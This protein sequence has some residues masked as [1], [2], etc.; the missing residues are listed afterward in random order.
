MFSAIEKLARAGTLL[1]TVCKA[2]DDALRVCVTQIPSNTKAEP[3][4][5]P[6]SLVGT[7]EELDAGFAE[8]IVIWQAPRKSLAEQARA[9]ATDEDDDAVAPASKPK[10]GGAKRGS[11]PQAEKRA[12]AASTPAAAG[13]DGA[14]GEAAPT[15]G[16]DA[17]AGAAAAAAGGDV[18]P[19][20][21]A[22]H[23]TG[24]ASAGDD[25]TPAPCAVP[26]D[27]AED[28]FT[29]DLF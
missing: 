9:A 29:L 14:G 22:D 10:G 13:E 21:G 11:K 1:V 3:T 19:A 7:P 5:R 6:L 24:A 18:A 23:M 26:A 25:A 20:P 2:D 16:V 15:P 12:A 27:G 8:A 17:A 28:T 4:L